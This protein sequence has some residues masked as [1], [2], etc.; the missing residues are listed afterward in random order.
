[1][2]SSRY[3]WACLA[4]LPL[5]VGLAAPARRWLAAGQAAVYAG[6][7]LYQLTVT[8]DHYARYSVF[9]LLLA[10]FLVSLLVS[11]LGRDLRRWRRHRG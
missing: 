5:L 8:G 3:Y 9:N 2:V 10:L 11:F 4:L 7:Y 6:F 1:M